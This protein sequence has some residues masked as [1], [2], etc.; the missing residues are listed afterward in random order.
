MIDLCMEDHHFQ[1]HGLGFR[2]AGQPLGFWCSDDQTVFQQKA[3]YDFPC[4][5]LWV[6]PSI[7]PVTLY[8][9]LLP[10]RTSTSENHHAK[11]YKNLQIYACCRWLPAKI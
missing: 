4:V 5:V 6:F 3:A 7:M 10:P 11:V 8:H 2:A 9:G 1:E